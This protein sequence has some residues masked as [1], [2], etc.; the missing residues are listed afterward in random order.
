MLKYSLSL[1]DTT[2]LL[3]H[4]N[5][6]YSLICLTYMPCS[7][8]IVKC[9]SMF[10]ASGHFVN[11]TDGDFGFLW[12]EVCSRLDSLKLLKTR[13]NLALQKYKPKPGDEKPRFMLDRLCEQE[14]KIKAFKTELNL[15]FQAHNPNPD[16][17]AQELGPSKPP[18]LP[19]E[20]DPSHNWDIPLPDL[21]GS[22]P[23]EVEETTAAVQER[24]RAERNIRRGSRR[25]RQSRTPSPRGLNPD[26]YTDEARKAAKEANDYNNSMRKHIIDCKDEQC[27]GNAHA[28]LMFDN[29]TRRHKLDFGAGRRATMRV[30][31]GG[32]VWD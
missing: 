19:D 15:W 8:L 11:G 29:A 17:E 23:D 21:D 20:L 14:Q 10:S 31:Q 7:D 5:W 30:A 18:T 12:S 2:F 24:Y 1:F 4:Q 16:Y 25:D 13:V 28:F 3:E 22:G 9:F 26:M 6:F 32:S 27:Q